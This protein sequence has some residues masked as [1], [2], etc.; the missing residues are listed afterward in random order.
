MA[1]LRKKKVKFS[2]ALVVEKL[3]DVPLLN[4]VIFAKVR[5]LECGS[6]VGTT[7]HRPVCSHQVD[8]MSPSVSRR[9]NSSA[10]SNIRMRSRTNSGQIYPNANVHRFLV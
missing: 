10:P 4:A 1:F 6:F 7:L 3:T 5:L 9:F 2:V 8:F